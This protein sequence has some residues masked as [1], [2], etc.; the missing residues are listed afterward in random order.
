MA[1]ITCPAC[2]KAKMEIKEIPQLETDFEGVA[3][4]VPNALVSECPTCGERSFGAKELRRW[5]DIKEKTLA[6]VGAV[7]D[8]ND[9]KTIREQFGLSVAQFA[10]LIAVTRQTVHSWERAAGKPM[11]LGPAAILVSLLKQAECTKRVNVTS[12]LSELAHLRG[13]PV[14]TWPICVSAD[15]PRTTAASARLRPSPPPGAC[16]WWKRVA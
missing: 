14:A 3:I 10:D 1:R 2:G 11:K 13:K 8:G 12:F 16:G 7:P 9:V 15:E 6:E 5:K 4:T